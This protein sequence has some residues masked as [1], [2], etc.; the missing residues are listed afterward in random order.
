MNELIE[1]MKKNEKPFGLLSK[2]EQ[3]WFWIVRATCGIEIY[4]NTN[5]WIDAG[6]MP[7]FS[8]ATTYRISPDYQPEPEVVEFEVGL[9]QAKEHLKYN[10]GHFTA[11]A[12]SLLDFA[13]YKFSDMTISYSACWKLIDGKLEHATHVRMAK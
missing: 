11:G 1:Q 2:D 13:G 4:H 8:K 7:V 12:V 3:N 5:G 10:N 6:Y 9:D